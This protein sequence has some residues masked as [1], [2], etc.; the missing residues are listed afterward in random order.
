MRRTY[1][2]MATLILFS[3]LPGTGKTRLSQALASHFGFLYSPKIACNLVCARRN[4]QSA[5]LQMATCS[6]LISPSS[7]FHL[8]SAPFSTAFFRW[9]VFGFVQR[10]WHPN[11]TPSFALFTPTVQ[12]PHFGKKDW[13]NESKTSQIGHLSAGKKWNVSSPTSSRGIRAQPFFWTQ[14]ILSKIIFPKPSLG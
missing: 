1:S 12:T 4:W 6:S 2:L 11:I 10:K 14:W 5:T 9:K 7:S 8:A 3:G 13:K